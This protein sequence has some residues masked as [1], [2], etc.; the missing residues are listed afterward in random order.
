[1]RW[2]Y[3]LI[4]F[5]I[6][7]GFALAVASSGCGNYS[8]TI[9]GQYYNYQPNPVTAT[10]PVNSAPP[11]DPPDTTDP[12]LADGD[13]LAKA[14]DPLTD[15]SPATPPDPLAGNG[16]PVAG[17]SPTH[18]WYWIDGSIEGG[19][20]GIFVNGKSIGQFTV[21]VDK[22]ITWF[23]HPGENTLTF[24][25]FPAHG[26]GVC[27]VF[28]SVVNKRPPAHNTILTY[29]TSQADYPVDQTNIDT[30]PNADMTPAVPDGRTNRTQSDAGA[31]PIVPHGQTN[32][33]PAAATSSPGPTSE[34]RTFFDE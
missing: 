19:R 18:G 26:Q 20:I 29:D 31:T 2:R 28:L 30:Q 34:T 17:G 3:C 5:G 24:V 22:E 25:H 6:T 27:N 23:C 8:T 16:D 7:A 12:L 33:V 13:P 10:R 11:D 15:D 9:H 1:M 21:R 32:H 14:G 4:L